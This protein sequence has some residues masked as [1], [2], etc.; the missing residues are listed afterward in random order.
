MSLCMVHG[1]V[2][3]NRI[4]TLYKN[5][6]LVISLPKIPYIHC[7]CVWFWPTLCMVHAFE[8]GACCVS[9]YVRPPACVEIEKNGAQLISP[10]VSFFATWLLHHVTSVALHHVTS[11]AL[12]HVTSVALHHVTSVALHHVTSVTLH[13]SCKR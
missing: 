6:Y 1:W 5:M 12:H 9:L 8:H 13:F 3:Q 4:H 11:V 7:M 2:G 10:V